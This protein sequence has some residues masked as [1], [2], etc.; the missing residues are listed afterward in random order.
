M[1]TA[2]KKMIRK[3]SEHCYP[4][5][6]QVTRTWSKRIKGK[7]KGNRTADCGHPWASNTVAVIF[8]PSLG[9]N[10]HPVRLL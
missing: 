8:A 1:L 2:Q 5:R 6:I 3:L 9:D 4:S 10:R 7:E